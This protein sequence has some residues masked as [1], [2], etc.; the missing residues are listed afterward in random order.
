VTANLLT[1]GM[2]ELFTRTDCSG[3]FT[4]LQDAL[5]STIALV[6][7]SGTIQTT[8]SYD[9]FGNTTVSDAPSANPAQYTGRENEGNGLYYYRNRY[10]SPVLHRF[11]SEDPA[12]SDPNFYAYVG[13]NP[14]NRRNPLGLWDTYSHHALFWNALRA[15][16]V[17]KEDIWQMQEESDFVDMIGTVS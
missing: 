4:P 10:Y 6:D 9:P 1:G 11:I 8:Y 15:C 14:I 2:D 5:G 17:G 3:S 12:K 7:S 13:D 16:G